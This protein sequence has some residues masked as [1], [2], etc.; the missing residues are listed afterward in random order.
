VSEREKSDGNASADASKS[1]GA[2]AADHGEEIEMS[3][4]KFAYVAPTLISQ[5]MF[6]GAAG[7]GKGNPRQFSCLV[8]R[9]GSS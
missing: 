4:R 2:V 3:R 9:R 1:G 5:A 6:Y 7:C 8:L